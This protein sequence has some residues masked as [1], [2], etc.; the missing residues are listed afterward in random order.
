MMRRIWVLLLTAATLTPQQQKRPVVNNSLSAKAWEWNAATAADFE[1]EQAIKA[2]KIPGAVLLVGKG[3]TILY[4]KAYGQRVL[5]P[6][7][8]SMSTNT[9]F[10][11]ASLTKIVATT[12]AVMRLFED[13]K[14]QIDEKVTKY[15]PEYQGGNSEITIRQLLTHYSGL[16]PDVDLRPEWSGYE[17]G[18]Q[19]A[20]ADK[21]TGPPG[22]K[23]VYSDI[24][25]LLLGE[26]VKRLSGMS[27]PEF[28]MQQVFQPLGMNETT[29][30][31]PAVW[32]NRIA[33]TE[34]YP[35]MSEPLRGTVHDETT[36]F[37][38]GIAGHAG[39]FSTARDLS[40][41]AQM[42]IGQGSFQGRQIFKP[43]T[44]ALFTSPQ[45]PAGLPDIRGLGFDID[46]RYSANRGDL[47]PAGTSF[48]HTGFTGTSI[49][50]DPRSQSYVILLTNS[51]HPQRRPAISALRR[52]IATIAAASV[53]VQAPP[54]QQVK[55]GLDV[56]AETSAALLKDKRI[57][58][59]TNHTG[60]S[61]DRK[62]NIDLM[63]AGGAKL[64][65]IFTPE[66]G[67]AGKL[68]TEKIDDSVDATSKV[69]VYSLYKGA[70]RTPNDEHLQKVDV[71]VFDIQDIG[72]RFYTYMCT[73]QNVMKEA[74]RLKKTF[75]VLDRPNPITGEHVEGPLLD[76]EL[77]SFIGC[78]QIPL[79]HGMTMGE[80]AQWMNA[81]EKI[82]VDLQVIR[83][84]GYQRSYWFDE[85]GLPWIDTSP[86]MRSLEAAILYPGIAM[87]EASKNLSVGRGT[88]S[89]FQLVGAPWIDGIRLASYLNGRQ[90]EGLRVYPITFR[91]NNRE[92]EGQLCSGVRFVITDRDRVSSSRVGVELAA[93]LL[94]LFP[95]KLDLEVNAKLIAN[96]T[97]IDQ[98]KSGQDP[99]D[100]A[101]AMES[102][103][104]EF[105]QKRKGYL[106]Y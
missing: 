103:V 39:L 2:N 70:Q 101:A 15:L 68:D 55:T 31:P 20:L 25:F 54:K 98:L 37:M 72:A 4:E 10:D 79:R 93:A 7:V 53:G 13:G 100:I 95:G 56:L 81:E 61:A 9:V 88:D 46:S 94:R 21:P 28:A 12:S 67:L 96:R 59:I 104:E 49:W 63:M 102:K 8:E 22:L 47:Y 43:Q 27:L 62:R 45:S 11:V 41:W 23:F 86:N 74:A 106:L 92:L 66:H 77:R 42:L 18:I 60:I 71:L 89:P 38:G 5:V 35:G 65:A 32:R 85:T 91:P 73:M 78:A 24:N 14:L 84:T 105:V 76:P 34:Q 51:V 3:S 64:Q 82:G 58:L 69:P 90:I 6:T 80:L 50:M 29:Y 30:N 57:G 1:I 97:L 44:V 75:I 99:A 17:T 26:I 52:R 19:L 48:G 16:R 87:L 33:P 36:R 40:K 83:M